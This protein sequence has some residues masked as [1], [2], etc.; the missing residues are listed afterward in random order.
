MD[1]LELYDN[2]RRSIN[3]G[4]HLI[5]EYSESHDPKILESLQTVKQHISNLLQKMESFTKE[6]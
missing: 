3:L 5:K 4:R 6:D 2:F 1:I